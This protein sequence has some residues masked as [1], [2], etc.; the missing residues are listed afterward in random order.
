MIWSQDD[1]YSYP[2][3]RLSRFLVLCM[4]SRRP[5]FSAAIA[6]IPFLLVAAPIDAQTAATQTGAIAIQ[7]TVK[8]TSGMAV[9]FAK[10]SAKSK[11]P[12]ASAGAVADAS[13]AFSIR[14]LPPGDYEV[15]ASAEGFAAQTIQ[16]TIQSESP[17]TVNITLSAS[18]AAPSLSDLGFSPSQTQGSVAEQE[19]LD[20]RTRML[21]LH[22]KLGLITTAPLVATVI[23]GA[24][25]GGRQ[26]SST[27]RDVH[28][29]IGSA[30]VGLYAATAY[31]S[32]FAPRIPGT[33]TRGPIRVHKILAWIHGAGMV[34]T[35]ILG[36]MAFSQKSK[37]EKV[38]GLASLHGPVGIITAGAYGAAILSVSLKW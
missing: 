38:H 37:G 25:A 30:T 29:A 24:S 27:I 16:I 33:D 21:K 36:E 6:I 35:P 9:A 7:G 3:A 10:I 31:Y 12:G 26:E 18:G 8:D 11:A 1:A 34:L 19:R 2:L 17:Q 23:L 32:I 22:Q 13:G 28:A 14:N 15:T 4:R 5:C 20:R